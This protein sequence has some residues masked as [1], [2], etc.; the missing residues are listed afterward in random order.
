MQ[1]SVE[2]TFI[3]KTLCKR[4]PWN[5]FLLT[6]A[7]HKTPAVSSQCEKWN[8]AALKTPLVERFLIYYQ[9]LLPD[10]SSILPRP[11]EI[12]PT[13]PGFPRSINK[14]WGEGMSSALLNTTLHF[15]LLSFTPRWRSSHWAVCSSIKLAAVL[16]RG[17][18]LS[19]GS[20][21]IQLQYDWALSYYPSRQR[22]K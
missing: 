22:P 16:E 12:C 7:G 13:L 1:S 2:A 10:R 15:L 11:S 17:C 9:R 5:V 21:G 14:C 19:P 6:K 3:L 8:V 4:V 20:S 18:R